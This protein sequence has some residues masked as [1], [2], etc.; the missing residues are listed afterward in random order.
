M[1]VTSSLVNTSNNNQNSRKLRL[2]GTQE[3]KHRFV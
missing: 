1:N 3:F 2:L